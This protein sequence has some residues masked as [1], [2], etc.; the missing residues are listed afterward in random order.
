[1]KNHAKKAFFIRIAC[2]AFLRTY[3]RDILLITDIHTGI[4]KIIEHCLFYVLTVN[5]WAGHSKQ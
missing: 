1:M 4:D 2:F 5:D 3:R